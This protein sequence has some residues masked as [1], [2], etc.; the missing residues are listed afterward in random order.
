DLRDTYDR[1]PTSIPSQHYD[2]EIVTM[3][4]A[5]QFDRFA[6]ACASIINN[7]STKASAKA[8][9]VKLKRYGWP[10]TTPRLGN[11]S[12][13]ARELNATCQ[14]Q[15]KRFGKLTDTI[16]DFYGAIGKGMV[17][18][19]V[20]GHVH[21]DKYME[22]FVIEHVGV[23]LKDI[24][25][26]ETIVQPLGCWTKSKALGKA[27]MTSRLSANTSLVGAH[28][29]QIN[30]PVF[31]VFNH[32]FRQYREKHGKGGDFVIYSDVKWLPATNFPPILLSRNR[33][34]GT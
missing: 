5:L 6:E 33:R 4:W 12:M 1:Y 26:F 10:T 17:Q 21:R 16:D 34:G 24:Y 29:L 15:T 14:I 8:L 2:D 7:Y 31:H 9:E 27:E 32:D 11:T 19:A 23:Y 3:D 30:E 28:V 20:V 25:E 22:L 18:L 13:T